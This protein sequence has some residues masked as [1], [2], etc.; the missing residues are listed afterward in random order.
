MYQ[1]HESY[2]KGFDVSTHRNQKNGSKNNKTTFCTKNAEVRN[3]NMFLSKEE[4]AFMF[5]LPRLF[6]NISVSKITNQVAK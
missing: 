4:F 1:S 5:A 6:Q 2:G 3:N